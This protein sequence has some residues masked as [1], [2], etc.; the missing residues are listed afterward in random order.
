MRSGGGDDADTEARRQP[1]QRRVAFVV[2]RLA[3]MSQLDADPAGGEPVHQIGQRLLRRFQTAIA[4]C[5]ANRTFPAP[6]EDVPMPTRRLGQRIEVVAQ[7]ALLTAGQMRRGQLP[8]QPSVAFRAT[9]KHQ[10][11]RAGRVRILGARFRT[12]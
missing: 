6:G 7:L 4:E 8:R 2:E 5:L 12:Q 11:M 3:M 1:G 9:G 10:Q